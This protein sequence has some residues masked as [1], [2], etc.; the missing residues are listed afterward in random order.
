MLDDPSNISASA[1]AK[2]K[3]LQEE[4]ARLSLDAKDD[5]LRRANEAIETLNA[6]GFP[7]ELMDDHVRRHGHAKR[8]TRKVGPCTVCGYATEPPHNA[9]KHNG[10]GDDKQPFSAEELETHGLRRAT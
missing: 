7:Y 5:A 4:I 3:Q 8:R 9:R 6:L 2:I 10:Q 1:V